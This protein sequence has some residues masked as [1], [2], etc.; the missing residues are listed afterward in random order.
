MEIQW[1]LWWWRCGQYEK[2]IGDMMVCFIYDHWVFSLSDHC[3]VT[4]LNASFG[5]V[6]LIHATCHW[7]SQPE[8]YNLDSTM[9]NFALNFLEA[10]NDDSIAKKN[11]REVLFGGFKEMCETMGQ[12][13]VSSLRA[14]F[15]QRDEQIDNL[16]SEIKFLKNKTEDME[17]WTRR[18]SMRIQGIPESTPGSLDDKLLDLFN[19]RHLLPRRRSKWPIGCLEACSDHGITPMLLPLKTSEK[20]PLHLLLQ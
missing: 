13:I 20:T 6:T 9:E 17:Q 14:E 15:R 11:L 3:C 18:G 5:S 16:K 10:L 4:D 1:I 7:E 12:N 19:T 8:I 2:G